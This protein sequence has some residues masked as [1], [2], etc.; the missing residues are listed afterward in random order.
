MAVHLNPTGARLVEPWHPPGAWQASRLDL[1][2][3]DEPELKIARMSYWGLEGRLAVMQFFYLVGTPRGQRDV[4]GSGTKSHSPATLSTETRSPIPGWS[5]SV[6]R[7]ASSRAASTSL[8]GPDVPVYPH[9][10]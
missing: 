7:K 3:I 9:G 8:A 2:A 5:S 6:M 1:A 10:P 4:R